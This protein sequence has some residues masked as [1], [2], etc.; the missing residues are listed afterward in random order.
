VFPGQSGAINRM[1][2]LNVLKRLGYGGDSAVVHGFRSAFR[3]W[4]AERTNYPR[5]VAE[6]ALAHVVGGATERA[7]A[8]SDLFAR[9]AEMMDDW[10]RFCGEAPAQ[11]VV[12]LRA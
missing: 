4:V 9:R 1:A 3:D 6:L 12:P 8:R 7:Y 11:V 5:E 10:A 2:M